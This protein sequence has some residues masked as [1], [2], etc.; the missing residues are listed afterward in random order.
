MRYATKA[1]GMTD[2]PLLPGLGAGTFGAL[3]ALHVGWN[4]NFLFMLDGDDKG[5][6]ERDRYTA[7]YGIPI[8]RIATIDQL[9][10][11]VKCIEDLLDKDAV[12]FIQ[13]ELQLTKPPSK[14]H[15]RRFFQERLASG[16]INQLS[17]TFS[18]NSRSLLEALKMRLEQ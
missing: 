9:V 13:S 6:F 4:L 18:S 3:A 12:D 17:Q 14:N 11:G 15:I 7:E 1:I 8:D 10:P 5:R 16:K 2:L